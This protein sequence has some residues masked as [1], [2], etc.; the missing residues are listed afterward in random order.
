MLIEI[1][2]RRCL[3]WDVYTRV[4]YLCRKLGMGEGGCR[5]LK[6]GVF[7]G[8]YVIEQQILLKGKTSITEISHI[9]RKFLGAWPQPK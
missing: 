4:K 7:L 1:M 8:A 9:S 6:G 5:L 3:L 2:P